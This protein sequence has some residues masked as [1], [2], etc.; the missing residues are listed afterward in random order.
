M[1][2]T[3]DIISSY[4]FHHLVSFTTF[5]GLK[6][7]LDVFVDDVTIHT[8][9]DLGYSLEP[10]ADYNPTRPPDSDQPTDWPDH[11]MSPLDARTRFVC[12]PI[13]P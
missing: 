10:N 8:A 5:D 6:L 9:K 3:S 11:T 12:A 2:E 1:R 13:T 4:L 7:D